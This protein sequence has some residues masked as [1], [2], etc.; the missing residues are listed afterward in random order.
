MVKAAETAYRDYPTVVNE[1]PESGKTYKNQPSEYAIMD[2]SMQRAQRAI[3]GSSD[4]AQLAQSY[5]WDKVAKEEFDDEY[6]DLYHNVVILAVLAQ[7][8]IDGIKKEFAVNPNDEIA[9]IREMP[10]MK[11]KKDYP[12]F[13]KYTHK[14]PA[15]KNG[16]ERPYDDI[17]KDRKKVSKRIDRD[18]VCPMNY[19]QYCLDRI[20]GAPRDKAIETSEFFVKEKGKAN[21]RQMSKIRRMIEEYDAYVKHYMIHSVDL[22]DSF[23]GIRERTEEIINKLRGMKISKPTMNRL[24]GTC[25][26]VMGKTNESKKYYAAMKYTIKTL[27]LLYHSNRERFLQNFKI[28]INT[29]HISTNPENPVE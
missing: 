14:I 6:K 12:L 2:A 5:F 24:I 16:I 11:R 25:L 8:S 27:N 22:D 9:R 23:N 13:M 10:C 26:G 19:L 17:K 18:I 3:G 21:D 7:V 28:P 4:S 20:Q 15:T 29:E 1:I